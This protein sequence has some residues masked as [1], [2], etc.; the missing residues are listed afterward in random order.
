MKVSA[1]VR[2]VGPLATYVGEFGAALS[3][4]GYTDLSIANQLRLVAHLSRWLAHRAIAPGQ[5][6]TH[7]VEQFIGDRRRTHTAFRSPRALAP[8][9]RF[10][11][12]LD[13]ISAAQPEAFPTDESLRRYRSHLSDDR[14]LTLRCIR[15]YL[16]VA[17]DFLAGRAPVDLAAADVTAWVR[18]HADTPGLLGRLTALRSVLRFLFLVGK[19]SV[20]LSHAVPSAACRRLVSLPKGLDKTETDAMLATCDRRT[21]TG[22]RDYAALLL[23]VRLGL[24]A[25]EVASLTLD[26]IDWRAGEV[27]IFGKGGSTGRLPVPSDVGEAIV[28][29]LRR[30]RR[31]VE[32]RCLFLQRCAP[33]RDATAGMV[34]ALA[35]R[36]LRAAGI[37]PSGAHRLRH[38]A[39]TQMLRR[40]AS[41]TEIA[42]VLRHRHID[43]TAIYAK[44]DRDRL[45][46]LAPPWPTGHT[47]G[48]ELLQE[49][50]QPWPGGAS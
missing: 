22:R 13:V 3:A 47:T 14:D 49:L 19:T 26:A 33:Y 7:V 17:D 39:A 24:R 15:D 9:L 12:A 23:M 5:I 27:V 4:R 46:T 16:G 34:K 45:R 48:I 11:R 38:S 8:F 25:G 41:L 21:T 10:L 35:R 28:S 36:A 50:A 6:T 31:Q 29:Y 42:Q 32:S 43:T 30:R 2:V 37:S 18:V 1:L 44:V 20:N 40:G